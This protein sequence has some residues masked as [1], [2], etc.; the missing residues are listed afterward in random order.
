MFSVDR[1][2]A[3]NAGAACDLSPGESCDNAVDD[4]ACQ[5]GYTRATTA[6][7]NEATDFMECSASPTSLRKRLSEIENSMSSAISESI[8]Q[9]AIHSV[10]AECNFCV[11]VADARVN[12]HPLIAVSPVFEETTG[13]SAAEILGKNCRFL[14]YGCERD[15]EQTA[16]LRHTCQTGEPFTGVLVNRKKSGEL[17]ANLLDLRGLSIAT[18]AETGEELWLLIGIQAEVTDIDEA[19]TDHM[20]EMQFVAN[21]IRSKITKEVAN[22]GV[23]AVRARMDAGCVSEWRCPLNGPCW[24]GTG[25]CELQPWESQL[26]D[27]PSLEPKDAA[28]DQGGAESVDEQSQSQPRNTASPPKLARLPRLAVVA[29]CTTV[30]LALLVR[31][32][33]DSSRKLHR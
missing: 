33:S 25:N 23:S 19:P 7:S 20:E 1:S 11:T 13:F 5:N 29:A 26:S 12:D 22:L 9:Q 2:W 6:S 28:L 18:N 17:F 21:K 30:L 10:V 15:P 8:L 14:N 32:V 31:R 3:L 24:M 4:A 16:A 27:W